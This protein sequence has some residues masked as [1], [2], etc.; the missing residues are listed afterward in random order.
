MTDRS[1]AIA[2]LCSHLCAGNGIVPLEPKEYSDFA[3]SLERRGFAPESL[4]SFCRD[5]FLQQLEVDEQQADR[6]L[7]LIDRSASLSFEIS[8]YENMGIALVTR[9]DA[10]Y[11]EKLKKK[12]K[13]AC[14]PLFYV[15]GDIALLKNEAI[16]YVGSR[17][18]GDSDIAF[19]QAMVRKT[20][21]AGYAV[22]SGGARGTD[23]V[24]EEAALINYGVSI[25]FLSDSLLR[26]LRN[27]QTNHAVQQGRLL[28]LS[29]VNPD[30]GFNVGV[31][32][33]RNKY[34]YAQ[35]EATVVV[36]ADYNKG[37]T[38]AGAVENL[39]KHYA[40]T[41]CWDHPSYPGNK[42]LIEKGAI[43]IDE[44][45]DGDI[46]QLSRPEVSD[47]KE[48]GTEFSS[49]ETNVQMSLFDTIG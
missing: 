10:H 38:W 46:R 15:V 13:N 23:S 30:A 42:A 41:F 2:V 20:V 35:S 9:A 19:T 22:V 39:S 8:R 34:I 29:V 17:S 14:P 31:A 6:L 44:D 11:P 21:D 3:A 24:A 28:L 33:M 45:W 47:L 4:L 16:G 27:A 18:V 7:R 36:K 48:N 32:M 1:M 40:L 37:G 26:K 49:P 43:P 25:A 5:D 12:L